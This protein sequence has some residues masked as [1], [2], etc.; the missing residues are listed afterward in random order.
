MFHSRFKSSMSRTQVWNI[1]S[2]ST[3]SSVLLLILRVNAAEPLSTYTVN[4]DQLY[5]F[6]E[7]Y[8]VNGIYGG[9]RIGRGNKYCQK[10]RQN[11]TLCTTNNTRTLLVLSSD[12]CGKK[13]VTR[14]FHTSQTN[15]LNAA[16]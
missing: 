15:S 1:T 10:T 4:Y 6:R 8:E 7:T 14:P 9:F 2:I 3:C 13:P 11:A 16:L 12:R 5:Q